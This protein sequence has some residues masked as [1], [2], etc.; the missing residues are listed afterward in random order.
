M[1]RSDGLLASAFI[2]KEVRQSRIRDQEEFGELA[3]DTMDHGR[4][5]SVQ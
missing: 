1:L 4:L 2:V 3:T 5:C